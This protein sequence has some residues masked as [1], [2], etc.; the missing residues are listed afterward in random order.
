M[1]DSI[2]HSQM[3][4]ELQEIVELCK[5][6]PA[7]LELGIINLQHLINGMKGF[8]LAP[9]AYLSLFESENN[10][11]SNPNSS[12][13]P[14]PLCDPADYPASGKLNNIYGRYLKCYEL[15]Q[16]AIAINN[17]DSSLYLSRNTK[18][19]KPELLKWF[20]NNWDKVEPIIFA[21]HFETMT[22]I[23]ES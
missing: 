18:R 23:V 21:N 22:F 4:K 5:Q 9:K 11:S 17:S 12:K 6:S 14:K 3:V 15:K 16:L 8:E 7:K 2:Q 1:S 13:K 10:N 20:T 19:S